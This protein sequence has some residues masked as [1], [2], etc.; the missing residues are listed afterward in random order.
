MNMKM[1]AGALAVT[2]GMAAATTASTAAAEV[3]LINVFE[4]P[5]AKLDAVMAAWEDARAFLAAQPGYIDTGLHRAL[6]PEARFQ[7]INV[8]RWDSAEAFQAAI[9]AMQAAGVFPEIEGVTMTPG[10]YRVIAE[11]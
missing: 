6:S 1:K 3:T 2:M 9:G 10:L 8:A 7:L 4:V 11:D 5:P